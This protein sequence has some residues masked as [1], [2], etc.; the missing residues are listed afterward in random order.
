MV[1]GAGHYATR[2]GGRDLQAD[3]KAGGAD[4]LERIATKL[5]GVVGGIRGSSIIRKSKAQIK[6]NASTQAMYTIGLDQG[7]KK[8]WFTIQH[9]RGAKK[10]GKKVMT[11][12]A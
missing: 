9:R 1:E 2:T 6:Q 10:M 7:S 4:N 11:L 8:C 5:N 3:L 12:W